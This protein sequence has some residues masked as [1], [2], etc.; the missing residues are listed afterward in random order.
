MPGIFKRFVNVAA[1]K[2]VF[3][4]AEDLTVSSP[5]PQPAEPVTEAGEEQPAPEPPP[6]P[7]EPTPVDFAQIQAEGGRPDQSPENPG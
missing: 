7:K 3:P 4:D 5:E 6:E 2:Y 1:D